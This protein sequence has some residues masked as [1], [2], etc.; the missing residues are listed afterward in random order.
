MRPV[1]CEECPKRVP[2]AVC[3][4][5]ADAMAEFRELA[6]TA[7]YRHG[8]VVF[9]EGGPAL[10]LHLVCQ[11]Q[12]KLFHSDRFGRP[13]ALEVVGPPAAIG[14]FSVDHDQAHTV[15]AEAVVD[16]QL[17][18][19]PRRRLEGLLERQPIVAW[20]LL[21][22]LSARLAA[23]RRRACDLLMAGAEGR[24]ASWLLQASHGSAMQ[25]PAGR[26]VE[27]PL[28]RRDVA[29]TIG[30]SLGTAVRLLARFEERGVIATGRHSMVIRDLEALRRRAHRDDAEG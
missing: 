18:F 13:H 19:L 6:T 27:L 1:A 20:R 25:A 14:E 29:E 8:Q 3:D 7:A 23:T 17:C 10:G 16:S 15:S 4:L 5:P 22:A 12:V 21:G 9:A 30:V 2:G 26:A 28:R 24:L 11:G